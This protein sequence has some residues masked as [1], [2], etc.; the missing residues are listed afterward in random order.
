MPKFDLGLNTLNDNIFTMMTQLGND[1]DAIQQRATESAAKYIS[2]ILKRTTTH[3]NHTVEFNVDNHGANFDVYTE[4][5]VWN[6]LDQGTRA[7]WIRP[8]NPGYPLRFATGGFVPKT[9]VATFASYPGAQASGS[10]V[11]T[12]EV[13]HPGTAAREWSTEAVSRFG[14]EAASIALTSMMSDFNKIMKA[15]GRT[16][17]LFSI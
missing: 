5:D 17:I 10:T 9:K 11:R 8:K 13:W 1:Y 2:T 14:G 3:W 6:M 16:T 7:H 12:M 4:D 15:G